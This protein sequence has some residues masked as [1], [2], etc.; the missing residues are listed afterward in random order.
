MALKRCTKC[1]AEKDETD[2][3]R[4]RKEG[5]PLNQCKSCVKAY[6]AAHYHA[7]KQQYFARNAQ[8][9]QRV[10][11][12]I[13]AMKQKPC[14]DCGQSYPPWVRDFDHRDGESKFKDI[15]KL[16]G[17][18]SWG[19]VQREIEKCDVVCAN[20]HRI[21]THNRLLAKRKKSTQTTRLAA[22]EGITNS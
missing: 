6:Q 12:L 5:P 20:C 7:N 1:H 4:R 10:A 9:R 21:R 8:Y 3:S 17:N 22:A 2:F 11:E 15:S 18:S 19:I 13:K 14:A 16:T